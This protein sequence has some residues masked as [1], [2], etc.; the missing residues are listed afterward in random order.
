M[1]GTMNIS[2]DGPIMLRIALLVSG[3]LFGIFLFGQDVH[4]GQFYNAPLVIN[5]A[6]AGDIEGDQRLVL[7]HREQ[8]RSLGSPFRTSAFSYDL[9]VLAGKL[10]GGRYLGIG[11][12]AFSDKAGSTRFGDTQANLSVSYAIKSGEESLIAF[13]LQGGYGQRSAVLDGMRWDSQY[14]S[15]GYNPDL[16]TNE[17]IANSRS[18]FADFGAGVLGKGDLK[19]GIGWKAGGSVFHL[20]QARVSLFGSNAD[21]LLRRY[22]V[23]GELRIEG[24]RW[25]W[26]PK[27]FL[28]QQGAS[29]EINV[30]G[31]IH[32]RIGV[33]SRYTTDKNSSAVYFGCFYR[34]KDAVVPTVQLEWKRKLMA[35]LSYDINISK[36][37]AQTSYRGGMEVSLQ[38]IGMFSDKRMKLPKG[39][40]R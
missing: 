11:V 16:P 29:R 3:I 24:E 39:L 8:W 27:F 12:S 35:G 13:G 6:N 28:A 4:F 21:R 7:I 25:I 36:L 34:Y 32:R 1:T 20:N 19:N 22:V 31:L 40:S 37:R 18:S 15:A 38:W 5:P 9:P 26:L 23:H 33:D 30:G 17:S 2:K 10:G 14:N